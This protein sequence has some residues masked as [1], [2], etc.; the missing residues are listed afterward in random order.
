METICL[1]ALNFA[2]IFLDKG[3]NLNR[4]LRNV[5]RFVKDL[6]RQDRAVVVFID[7]SSDTDEALNKWKGRR[8][9][10]IMKQRKY[11]P[12]GWATLLGDMFKKLNIDVHYSVY[13][14]DD[15]IA[16]YAYHNKCSILSRDRDFYRYFTDDNNTPFRVY[17]SIT[18]R[19]GITLS[20][21][22]LDDRHS[23]G[24]PPRKIGQLLDTTPSNPFLINVNARREYVRGVPT[25]NVKE[26]GNP[27]IL[28]TE[29]RTAVYYDLGYRDQI[30]E[31]IPYYDNDMEDV[32]WTS[33]LVTPTENCEIIRSPEEY[34]VRSG[35][36]TDTDTRKYRFCVKSVIYELWQC[37]HPDMLLF[38]ILLQNTKYPRSS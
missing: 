11:V 12:H 38:D 35:H 33:N 27:H 24:A 32:Q 18:H 5:T 10:E 17:A 37:L 31:I 1:D 14:C 8:V 21:R 22:S 29:F 9:K 26:R 23:R 28:F 34:I 25:N 3:W 19:G 15:T 20:E 2:D 4:C 16:H 6:H 13:D 30:R 7:G 36:L